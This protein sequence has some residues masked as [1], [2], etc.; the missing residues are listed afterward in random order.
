MQQLTLETLA[1][2]VDEAPRPEEQAALDADPEAVR[3][4]AT[5]RAQRDALEDLPSVLPAEA[6]PAVEAK[7][8]AAGLIRAPVE[9][10]TAS[11]STRAADSAPAAAATRLPGRRWYQAAAALLMF[12][13]GAVA[14][15][16]AAPGGQGPIPAG[17][18]A[19]GRMAADEPAA[20]STVEDARLA[21][22]AAERR[23]ISANDH[24]WRL[25]GAR[26]AQVGGGDPAARLA[27]LEGLVAVSRAAV[28]ES[29]SDAFFNGFLVSALAQRQQA[30][31]Q[32]GRAGWY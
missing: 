12:A 29:P 11:S 25:V 14:G 13:G 31:R 22:Q 23:W 28:A 4:L 18:E 20:P 27:A 1:R 8:L 9:R 7:L 19:V 24:Y 6:W 5:L 15:W 10:T 30:L 16:S 3:E 21:V 2:L 26:G 17:A 32:I